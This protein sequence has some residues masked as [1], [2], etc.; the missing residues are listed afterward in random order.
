MKRRPRHLSLRRVAPVGAH[1]GFDRG[2]PV[3][4]HYIEA[5]LDRHR[6]DVRGCVL[7]VL[8]R[9]YTERFGGPRVTRSDV[10]DINAANSVATYVDD[11]SAPRVLPQGAFDCFIC[12]QTLQYIYEIRAA[13]ATI[14]DVLAPGGV[15][16]VTVPGITPIDD[17]GLATWYWSLT[18]H[19]AAQLFSDAFGS[20]QVRVEGCG[21][22][23]AATALL[24]GLAAEDLPQDALSV[25]DTR[26]DLL[27]TVRAV[28][29]PEA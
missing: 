8:D 13:V 3:D 28:R 23:L 17:R 11:L 22:A 25:R 16:L 26:Y 6:D 18:R 4:R 24:Q 21:N 5:F 20:D 1:F 2:T 29:L 12:T 15:A 10:V 7:E 27:V 14:H 19:A 9:S